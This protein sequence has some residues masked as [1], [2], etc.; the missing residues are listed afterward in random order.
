MSEKGKKQPRGLRLVHSRGDGPKERTQDRLPTG[1]EWRERRAT[2][3]EQ[4]AFRGLAAQLVLKGFREQPWTA[5]G[6]SLDDRHETAWCSSTDIPKLSLLRDPDHYLPI[7]LSLLIKKS[8]SLNRKGGKQVRED[9]SPGKYS[10]FFGTMPGRPEHSE[11]NL[12]GTSELSEIKPKVLD[13][14]GEF[15]KLSREQ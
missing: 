1:K 6:P 2:I 11:L 10:V 14:F 9:H 15:E 8:Y 7:G 12:Q 13:A 3:E 5:Y 4:S